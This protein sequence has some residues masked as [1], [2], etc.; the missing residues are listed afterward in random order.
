[1]AQNIDN[2]SE[3]DFIKVFN[4][5][6]T[7]I[8]EDPLTNFIQASGFLNFSPTPAQRVVFKVLFEQKLDSDI[9][10]KIGQDSFDII[11]N[12]RLSEVEMTEVQLFELMT[13]KQYSYPIPKKT[14]VD[15]ICGRRSGKSTITAALTILLAIINNYKPFLKKHPYATVLVLS[16]SKEFSEEVLDLIRNFIYNSDI[17]TRLLDKT[18]TRKDRQTAF[19]M[20]V[21]FLDE[22]MPSYSNVTLRVGAANKKTVRGKATCVLICDEIAFWNLDENAADKDEDIIRAARPALAQFKEYGYLFKLSSPSIKQGILY[23][24]YLQSQKNELPDDYVVFKAPTWIWNSFIEEKVFQDE[25][26]LDPVGFNAEYRAEFVD[27]ISNFIM[28][29]YV[30]ACILKKVTHLLPDKKEDIL[31]EAA[32]DAAFKGDRF[33]FTIVG[34]V[35][36]RIRQYILLKWQGSKSKPL[37]AHD[38]AEQIRK[39]CKDYDVRQIYADQYAFQPL[40]EIFAQYDLILKEKTFTNTLKKQIFF[41]LKKLIHNKQID[42]LDDSVLISETKQLQIEQTASGTIRIGHPV[43]GH[44]DSVSVLALASFILAET[45]FTDIDIKDKEDLVTDGKYGIKT[46]FNTGRT[47]VAPAPEMLAP[48]FGQQVIDNTHEYRYDPI[49]K[50]FIKIEDEEEDDDGGSGSARFDFF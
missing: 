31:Y 44:D 28:P 38:I 15:L 9:K 7:K 24:E 33:T 17:L 16:H 37:K 39:V 40:S 30:D 25:Y 3:V 20:R 35:R 1:M 10:Y 11:G 45:A 47:V 19:N 48:F 49:T 2:L 22:G 50:K 36:N 14:K 12:F 32:I 21:P 23:K 18:K 6:L 8:K 27:A 29:E 5:A 43:G 42:L 4:A 46:D 13:G 26:K 41:N 34:S